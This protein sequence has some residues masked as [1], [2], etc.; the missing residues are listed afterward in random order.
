[1]MN[2]LQRGLQQQG[3][4]PVRRNEVGPAAMGAGTMDGRQ[5]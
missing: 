3:A 2:H 5:E 1:M 4:Q